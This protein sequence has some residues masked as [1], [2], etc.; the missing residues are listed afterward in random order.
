MRP[1]ADDLKLDKALAQVE[2]VVRHANRYFDASAPWKLKKTDVDRM[3]VVLAVSLET[4]R[5]IAIAYQPFM[6]KAA[7]K[8]LDQLAV[9]EGDARS[10]A[11]LRRPATIPAGT[12]LLKPK[13]IFPRIEDDAN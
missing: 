3:N 4:L 10:F 5:C 7:S 9:P 8:M 2:D 13:P 12:K 1:L 6:P 11:A